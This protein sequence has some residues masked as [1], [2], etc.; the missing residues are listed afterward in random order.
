MTGL[1]SLPSI[2]LPWIPGQRDVPKG[3]RVYRLMGSDYYHDVARARSSRP[4]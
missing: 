4:N 1:V 3:L 2:F